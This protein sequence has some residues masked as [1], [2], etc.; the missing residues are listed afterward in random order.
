MRFPLIKRVTSASVSSVTR[1]PSAVSLQASGRNPAR[2]ACPERRRGQGNRQA[3]ESKCASL[4]R[5]QGAFPPNGVCVPD[6][7]H[8]SD[9]ATIGPCELRTRATAGSALGKAFSFNCLHGSSNIKDVMSGCPKDRPLAPSVRLSFP[10]G[11][12]SKTLSGGRTN[13]SPSLAWD[14]SCEPRSLNSSEF[15]GPFGAVL[16]SCPLLARYTARATTWHRRQ[17]HLESKLC[18]ASK[19]RFPA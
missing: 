9:M 8:F 15:A 17:S 6:R 10:R 14:S 13:F 7:Q 12:G 19:F 16:V 3:C 18:P 5:D 11:L 2:P 1:K 4:S